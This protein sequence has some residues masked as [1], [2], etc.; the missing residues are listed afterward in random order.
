VARFSATARCKHSWRF[1]INALRYPQSEEVA[2]KVRRAQPLKRALLK[3]C[4]YPVSAAAIPR[5]K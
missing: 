1:P 4:D 2:E 5:P 3:A